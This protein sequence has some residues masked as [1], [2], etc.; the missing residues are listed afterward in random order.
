[1]KK[2]LLLNLLCVSFA[3]SQ[4]PSVFSAGGSAPLKSEYDLLNERLFNFSNRLKLLEESQEGLKSVFGSYTQKIQDNSYKIS[5]IKEKNLEDTKN[6]LTLNSM[7]TQVD[8][9]FKLQNENIEK[10]KAS[11]AALSTLIEKTNKQTKEE[12]SFLKKELEALKNGNDITFKEPKRIDEKVDKKSTKTREVD[13]VKNDENLLKEVSSDTLNKEEKDKKIVNVDS[14]KK[15]VKDSKAQE[16]KSEEK[17]IDKQEA[18]KKVIEPK[19]SSDAFKIGEEYFEKKEYAKAKENLEFALKHTYKPAKS[20]YLLGEIAFEE[21][22]FEDAI[23]YYRAS[24]TRYD[25]ADYM[26]RL[27][28]NSAKSFEA[29]KDKESATRF[30]E[31]LIELYPKSQEAIEAKKIL[32]KK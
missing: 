29:I 16:I 15:E 20:N 19:N 25:K 26:P 24:A 21:K 12:I 3:F 14:I 28:L 23:Y 13:S 1:M 7:K 22:K 8:E 30:L 4:E 32:I 6:N 18:K 2:I 5:E 27:L 9:N 10:I 31:T 11:I 17:V